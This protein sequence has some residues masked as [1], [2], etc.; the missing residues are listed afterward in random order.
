MTLADPVQHIRGTLADEPIGARLASA[1]VAHRDAQ[2]VA[3]IHSSRL[4]AL[5]VEAIDAGMSQGDVAAC[6]GF[7]RARVHQILCTE[8]RRS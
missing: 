7:S 3:Q 6:V 5:V 8:L 1:A 2:E 4:R